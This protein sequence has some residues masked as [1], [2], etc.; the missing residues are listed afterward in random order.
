[1]LLV[2]SYVFY[3]W[4]NPLYAFLI[5]GS[6]GLDYIVGARMYSAEAGRKRKALLYL[7]LAGNLGMLWTFKYYNF[8]ATNLGEALQYFGQEPLLGASDLLLPVGISFYT[9]QSMS[10]TIDIY[11]GRLKPCGNLVEFLLFVSFFPQLVAGPIV[12]A[13][14]FLPQF[15]RQPKYS[16][17]RV[18]EGI[19]RIIKG[20]FKKLVF[21]DTIGAALVDPVF[22]NPDGFGTLAV[23]LAGFAF[24]LQ[25]Y[26]DFSAYSD[27]AIGSAKMIG[28]KMPE[29]FNRPLNATSIQDFWQRW[30][31]SLTTWLR[32]YLY[33]PLVGSKTG[34]ITTIYATL[35]TF[36]LCGLWHGAS[37][38][39]VL[40]GAFHG[41]LLSI[42]FLYGSY[43]KGKGWKPLA[44]SIPMVTITVTLILNALGGLMFRSDSLGAL[45]SLLGRLLEWDGGAVPATG[46]PLILL[47]VAFGYCL[48][49]RSVDTR[50]RDTF[51][52]LPG[53]AQGVCLSM[54]LGFGTILMA[55]QNPFIYFQ[56]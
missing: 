47:A 56:F 39:F 32:D 18:S 48:L 24:M 15:K 40:F 8:F 45:G 37:W 44:K 27:I 42:Q 52:A 38:H 33:A 17:K 36:T 41:V 29:N 22:S 1:M 16:D 5:L 51:V 21:A 20:L 2:A 55:E 53:I 23:L 7:S 43:A 50:I 11:R 30:H 19:F 28:F 9:F 54:F 35:V 25:L 26:A 6:S 4:W 31:I 12:R 13:G 34:A 46:L 49:P 3:M 10:Y 14:M